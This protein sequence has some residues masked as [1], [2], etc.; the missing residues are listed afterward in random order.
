MSYIQIQPGGKANAKDA[1]YVNLAWS[2]WDSEKK[3]SV[4]QRFYVGRLSSCG[5]EVI[6]NKRFSG[7]KEIRLALEEVE[8]RASDKAAF[9]QWLHTVGLP[10][11]NVDSVVRV[12]I[13]GDAWLVRN[14]VDSCGLS[15]ELESLFGQRDTGALL[16]LAAHQ[17]A[18][19]HA[20]YRA[21]AWLSEREL[22]ESWKSSRVSDS[23]VYGF[24][25]DIGRDVE[26][27]ERFFERWIKRHKSSKAL[28]YDTTS[29]STYS[30][31]LE[32]AEWGYNRDEETLEQINFS[33]A[34][35]TTGM[36]LFYRTLP[37]SIPDVSSLSVT[38][39]M[40]RDY[41]LEKFTLSLDR[42]FYSAANLRDLLLLNC[43]FIIGVPWSVA[44]AKEL[45]KSNK[46]KL[47]ALKY[48]FTYR[49]K[50]LRY[51]KDN[52]QH[53]GTTINAHLYFDLERHTQIVLGFEKRLFALLEQAGRENFSNTYEARKWLKENAKW[54]TACFD[55]KAEDNQTRI[56][57]KP[58]RATSATARSGY[59]LILTHG[60]DQSEETQEMVLD[61][62][63]GR[64]TVEK[65][66]DILKTEHA[67]YRLRTGD[68][69]SVQGRIFIA[70]LALIIRA[71]LYQKMHNAN[72]GKSKTQAAILDELAKHKV[73]TTLKGNR[74]PLEVSKKQREILK[75]LNVPPIS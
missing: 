70:F 38:L 24:V 23:N 59:T 26:K 33:L 15:D 61:A 71:E 12:E 11:D 1:K 58:N 49:G 52:W 44:Q 18:T 5:C 34:A 36:P 22:P 74:I 9:E 51:M 20:L 14:L 41:G 69:D 35:S 4:Q 2:K 27:R 8:R 29:I 62:Y 75:A 46:S 68:N 42:G 48:A 60:R 19:G 65:L 3:R 30:D 37:G 13:C 32:L 25:G 40:A 55:V 45:F 66:F 47:K 50:P 57:L 67:Q 31:S 64:D 7:S 39:K 6:L 10:V 16:G 28:I 21:E 53:E 63:R 56:T 73:L 72:L 43:G 54:R 17:F